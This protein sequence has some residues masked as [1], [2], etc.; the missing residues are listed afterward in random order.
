M[1]APGC[2]NS[3]CYIEKR[4]ILIHR[5]HKIPAWITI[6][7]YIP[8]IHH[9]QNTDLPLA[10]VSMESNS[11]FWVGFLLFKIFSKTAMRRNLLLKTGSYSPATLILLDHDVL[12]ECLRDFIFLFGTVL[13]WLKSYLSNSYLHYIFKG[14]LCSSPTAFSGSVGFHFG[15]IL[16]QQ[17]KAACAQGCSLAWCWVSFLC[18]QDTG[19]FVNQTSNFKLCYYH[20]DKLVTVK[21]SVSI[22][23]LQLKSDKTELFMG[24]SCHQP[25]P[26]WTSNP[27]LKFNPGSLAK[28][29]YV[30]FDCKLFF[31]YC[32]QKIKAS[33]Y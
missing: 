5:K 22:N 33:Y 6:L 8:I 4:A 17:S 32:S 18:R 20:I 29:P 9:H 15:S 19:L 16:T 3:L 23:F 26:T 21:A 7:F 11:V 10:S 13:N 27:S 24:G 14:N 30:I 1:H 12:L 28:K 31:Q 25:K 2:T